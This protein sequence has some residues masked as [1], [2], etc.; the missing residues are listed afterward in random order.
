MEGNE[1]NHVKNKHKQMGY[2]LATI[3]ILIVEI[4][5][6]LYVHDDFIR[7]YIGDVLV[8][9]VIYTFIRIWMPNGVLL[10]PLYIYVFAI[11]VEV[12]Q[13]LHIVDILGLQNNRFMSVLI[14]GTFDWKDIMCYG[15]GCIFL[16][17]LDY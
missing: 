5:I 3:M 17:I 15:V 7:P 14:G 4:F 12:M 16:M 10:L 13:Y 8:V 11:F 1:L 6:A 2:A 9:I